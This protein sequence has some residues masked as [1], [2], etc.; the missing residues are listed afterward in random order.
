MIEELRVKKGINFK[1]GVFKG[2]GHIFLL[3]RK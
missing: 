3:A 1:K 2:G